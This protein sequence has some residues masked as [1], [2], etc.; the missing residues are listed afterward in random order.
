MLK[1]V[2]TSLGNKEEKG[3]FFKLYLFECCKIIRGNLVLLTSVDVLV[4]GYFS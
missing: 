3:L 1:P 4:Q 2:I